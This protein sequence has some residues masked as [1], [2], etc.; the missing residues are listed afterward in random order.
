MKRKCAV[1][2]YMEAIAEESRLRYE[3]YL[4]QNEKICGIEVKQLTPY[5]LAVLKSAESPFV[6]GGDFDYVLAAQFIWA[7]SA[8]FKPRDRRQFAHILK[9]IERNFSIDEVDAEISEYL[10][11]AFLDAPTESGKQSKPIA[12]ATAWIVYRFRD[13]PFLQS[14]DVTLHRPFRELYQELK[15]WLKDQGESVMNQSD[16]VMSRWLREINQQR[17]EGKITI[18]DIEEFAKR[19]REKK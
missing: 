9:T 3:I 10:R 15:C 19:N 6:D 16:A 18:E 12:S 4:G 13:V 17:A 7:V 8:D 2:G 14:R 5:L 1:P 11:I